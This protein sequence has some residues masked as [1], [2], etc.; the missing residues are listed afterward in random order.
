LVTKIKQ[1]T[2][3]AWLSK[4]SIIGCRFLFISAASTSINGTNFLLC[5][6]SSDA[7]NAIKAANYFGMTKTMKLADIFLFVNDMRPLNL[8][9]R[10]ACT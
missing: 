1:A 3:G 9:Q 4:S 5:D 8:E 7:A 10:V 6:P 2:V